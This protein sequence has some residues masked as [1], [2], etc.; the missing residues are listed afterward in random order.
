MAADRAEIA[1][2]ADRAAAERARD[3]LERFVVWAEVEDGSRGSIVT[4]RPA[5]RRRAEEILAAAPTAGPLPPVRRPSLWRRL[6]GFETLGAVLGVSLLVLLAV[7]VLI[8]LWLAASLLGLVATIVV[9][10]AGM[11]YLAFSGGSAAIHEPEA[12]FEQHGPASQGP[13]LTVAYRRAWIRQMFRMGRKAGP[14]P[15]P[16]P[17]PKAPTAEF[18]PCTS[19]GREVNAVL[20]WCPFC[21]E[22]R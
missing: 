15:D 16:R 11:V 20:E 17:S 6:F 3:R 1:A 4:V 10:V 8:G 9:V 2:F 7:G 14:V 18:T 19:C 13:A 22:P 5:D 12:G 21:R